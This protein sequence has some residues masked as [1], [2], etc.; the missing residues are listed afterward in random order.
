MQAGG[1]PVFDELVKAEP[2]VPV[3][4]GD[5]LGHMGFYQMPVENDCDCQ[6]DPT[7]V[8]WARS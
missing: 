5:G 3:S 2:A 8:M 1:A 6:P 4:A 7:H